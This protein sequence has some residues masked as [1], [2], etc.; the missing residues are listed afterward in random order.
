MQQ[1]GIRRVFRLVSITVMK[2]RCFYSTAHTFAAFYS[3]NYE[4][5]FATVDNAWNNAADEWGSSGI[6]TSPKKH[7][8]VV[9]QFYI[10]NSRTKNKV[11]NYKL[12][13]SIVF[14][15]KNIFFENLR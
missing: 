5:E 14:L 2:K 13:I 4:N 7:I 1:K 6:L 9:S 10:F 15:E 3:I 8:A 11:M 12:L